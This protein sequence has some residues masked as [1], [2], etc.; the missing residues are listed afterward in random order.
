MDPISI[1]LGMAGLAGGLLGGS[2]KSKGS[3]KQEPAAQTPDQARSWADFMNMVYGAFDPAF[4][5]KHNPDIVDYYNSKS[6][7]PIDLENPSEEAVKW[8][9]DHWNK[10]GKAEGRQG[11]DPKTADSHKNRIAEDIAHQKGADTAFVDQMGGLRSDYLG[12]LGENTQGRIGA[13]DTY[14]QAMGGIGESYLDKLD[15]D[16]QRW[17]GVNNQLTS[18]VKPTATSAP[19]SLSMGDF[20][21]PFFTGTQRYAQGTLGDLA[22]QSLAVQSNLGKTAYDVR[23]DQQG[24]LNK[25]A[26][27]NFGYKDTLNQETL[28]KQGD[29]ATLENAVNTRYMP[30]LADNTYMAWLQ[31]LAMQQEKM[32]YGIPG[33]SAEYT[34][35]T[36]WSGI[37]ADAAG[38]MDKSGI[39]GQG[40]LDFIGKNIPGNYF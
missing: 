36:N 33:S 13:N 16:T 35:P 21:T 23:G 17:R 19:V 40:I 10:Y 5:L 6:R 26:Q 29:Q 1:G 38:L 11:N 28:G 3:E 37:A 12:A 27:E 7:D 32:R 22:N 18:T 25:L 2:S 8:A 15:K 20:S 31:D 9:Y 4:Y 24:L 30:N 34:A 39:T 14:G